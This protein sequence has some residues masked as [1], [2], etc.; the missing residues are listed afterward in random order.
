MKTFT[1]YLNEAISIK[2]G[3]KV[4]FAIRGVDI[5]TFRITGL[6]GRD[7][8]AI[9]NGTFPGGP[10]QESEVYDICKKFWTHNP[11]SIEYGYNV[12]HDSK[13]EFIAWMK[14]VCGGIPSQWICTTPNQ[15]GAGSDRSKGFGGSFR[16]FAGG[17]RG[18][19]YGKLWYVM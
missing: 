8:T 12:A 14:E 4:Y 7:A 15:S 17:P 9:K 18:H 13:E 10:R 19:Q 1:E 3:A 5:Q 2:G 16:L 6:E 11:K